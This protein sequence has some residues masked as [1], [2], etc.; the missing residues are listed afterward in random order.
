[1]R[2]ILD[3]E[4]SPRGWYGAP[5]GWVDARG[6][7]EFVVALRCGLVRGAQAW[8]FAGGGMVAGSDPDAEWEETALKMRP[9]LRALGC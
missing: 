6:D 3:H 8:L 1:V 9:M 5:I 4:P 2:W 7:A